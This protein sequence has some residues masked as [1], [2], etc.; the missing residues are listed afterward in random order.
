MTHAL[1]EHVWLA[2]LGPLLWCLQ[3][4]RIVRTL[5]SVIRGEVRDRWLLA[6]GVPEA[7]RHELAVATM[8]GDLES[9]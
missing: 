6:K 1:I 5:T 4:T 2:P 8:R 3:R 9:S 7:T